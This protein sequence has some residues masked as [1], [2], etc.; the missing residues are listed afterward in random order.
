MHVCVCV[1]VWCMQGEIEIPLSSKEQ[2]I[3]KLLAAVNKQ[4]QGPH[5]AM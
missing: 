1:C 2:F 4:Q 5:H 3:N